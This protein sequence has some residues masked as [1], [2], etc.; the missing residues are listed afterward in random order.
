MF[1]GAFAVSDTGQAHLAL[2]E[3]GSANRTMWF[4]SVYLPG[5]PK[6]AAS[7]TE[8]DGRPP[9][10]RL[11]QDIASA[12]GGLFDPSA[13]DIVRAQQDQT[14]LVS[15]RDYILALVTFLFLIDVAVRRLD[16]PVTSLWKRFRMASKDLAGSFRNRYFP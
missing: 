13:D 15:L 9:N 10:H 12:T 11:L 4:G 6:Q 3:E 14:V 1:E 16:F 8:L 2:L 5:G 7:S